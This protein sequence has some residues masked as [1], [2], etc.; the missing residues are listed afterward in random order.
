M[1]NSQEPYDE[2][3]LTLDQQLSFPVKSQVVNVFSFVGQTVS[4]MTTGSAAVA[5]K[6][7]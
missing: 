2:R 7:Q 4:V 5:Q 3:T 1:G 6:P